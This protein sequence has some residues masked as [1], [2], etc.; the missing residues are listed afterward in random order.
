M[1][2]V[3]V[4]FFYSKRIDLEIVAENPCPSGRKNKKSS[5]NY[6]LQ[7]SNSAPVHAL[8]VILYLGWGYFAFLRLLF[9]S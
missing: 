2:L 7:K 8:A 3:K 1:E 5:E 9:D 6:P 4:N